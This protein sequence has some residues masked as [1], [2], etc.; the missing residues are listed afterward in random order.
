LCSVT[1]RIFLQY[2]VCYIDF[3]TSLPNDIYHTFCQY[4]SFEMLSDCCVVF[5]GGHRVS[6]YTGGVGEEE[7]TNFPKVH[8]P[9]SGPRPV[10]RYVKVSVEHFKCNGSPH[11]IAERRVPELIPVLGSQPAGDVSHKH[12]LQGCRY[13][14]PGPPL[15]SQPLRG[16]LP[17]LLLG[18]QRHD[19]REQFA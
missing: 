2:P 1:E 18:E 3:S 10:A 14:P 17:V 6:W 19:G 13:F 16:L 9:R 5:S 15:P 7:E 4:M 8:V 11:S 12:C